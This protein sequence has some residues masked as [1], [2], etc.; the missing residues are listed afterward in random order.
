MLAQA[1]GTGI[2]WR[3]ATARAQLLSLPPHMGISYAG[4]PEKAKFKNI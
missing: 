2:S 3:M 4:T 1:L